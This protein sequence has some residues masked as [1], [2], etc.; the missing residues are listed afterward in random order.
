MNFTER[1]STRITT[2]T[3]PV[4]S[5][6][7]DFQVLAN[8][9]PVDAFE[10]LL[11]ASKLPTQLASQMIE[12]TGPGTRA[13][14]MTFGIASP[15]IEGTDPQRLNITGR[16]SAFMDALNVR[17]VMR[18]PRAL[19]VVEGWV[20]IR[21]V[22]PSGQAHVAAAASGDAVRTA[23]FDLYTGVTDEDLATS[24]PAATI[25]LVRENDQVRLWQVSG[26]SRVGYAETGEELNPRT[27]LTVDLEGLT[28][29]VAVREFLLIKPAGTE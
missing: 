17:S 4:T 20:P 29:P 9:L 5:D 7:A 3:A 15:G 8:A 16:G 12:L 23:Y 11:A 24:E 1:K 27:P 28:A 6:T 19:A 10:L 2:A 25:K 21:R 18:A 22:L 14:L 13:L 26:S